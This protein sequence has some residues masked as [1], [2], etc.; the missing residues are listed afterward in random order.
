MLSFIAGMFAGVATFLA[1][2]FAWVAI[3]MTSK[4]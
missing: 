1:V 4:H 3:V 2:Y